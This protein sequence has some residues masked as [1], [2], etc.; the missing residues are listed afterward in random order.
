MFDRLIPVREHTLTASMP[1]PLNKIVFGY[2]DSSTQI[3][4]KFGIFIFQIFLL[5]STGISD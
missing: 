2:D 3:P 4:T 1:I 5:L